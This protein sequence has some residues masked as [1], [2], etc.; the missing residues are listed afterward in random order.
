MVGFRWGA[1]LLFLF[2]IDEVRQLLTIVILFLT[3][4]K[5]SFAVPSIEE[6]KSQL[7]CST[8]A[9]MHKLCAC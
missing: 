3:K 8:Y 2:N 9:A 7:N 1:I 6:E 5:V 4:K